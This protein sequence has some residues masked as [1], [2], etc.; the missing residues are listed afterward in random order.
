MENNN[1]KRR[2]QER[3]HQQ[4]REI[5]KHLLD[6]IDRYDERQSDWW[7]RDYSSIS[8]YRESIS[9]PR[10]EWMN[11]V[12]KFRLSAQNSTVTSRLKEIKDH[13]V[14]W[15]SQQL[16]ETL[17]NRA[18]LGLPD[19]ANPPY[20]LVICQHGYQGA[21]ENIFGL[22]DHSSEIV[23]ENIYGEIGLSLLDRGFAVLAPLHITGESRNNLERLAQLLGGSLF[24]F[25]I[26]KLQCWVTAV[27][28][29]KEINSERIGMWGLSMGGT[30]TLFA[31]PIVQQIQAGICGAFFNERI[32][33]M[34][35]DTHQQTSFFGKQEYEHMYLPGWLEY[36]TDSDLVSMICPR[37][38]MIQCGRY[39]RATWWVNVVDEYEKAAQHYNKLGIE[40]RI[41]LDL[42]EG[43]HEVRPNKGIAFLEEFL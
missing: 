19:T 42:H 9:N 22:D 3:Q 12:G 24:G 36:F 34:T 17:E 8:A 6:K 20:P 4:Y 15:R 5:H 25:E 27:S 39:D 7:E 18:L 14:E 35:N 41:I 11:R 30:Y 40:N 32:Q 16:T 43:G 21:P 2:I 29:M 23:F 13:K 26:A 38:F 31:L 10:A 33:K 37:P 1:L 28:K